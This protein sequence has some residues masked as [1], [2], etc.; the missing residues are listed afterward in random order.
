[1][2]S[3]SDSTWDAARA[4]RVFTAIVSLSSE[5]VILS[6]SGTSTPFVQT[7]KLSPSEVHQLPLPEYLAL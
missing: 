4:T 2:Q 1:M 6:G 7:E 5:P 3:I